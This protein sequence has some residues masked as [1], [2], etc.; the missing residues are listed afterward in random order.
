MNETQEIPSAV[1]S[2]KVFVSAAINNPD[3]LAEFP[4]VGEPHFH[5]PSQRIVFQTLQTFSALGKPF[6]LRLIIQHLIDTGRL[7]MAG[8]PSEVYGLMTYEVYSHNVGFH[9]EILQ[10][11]LARRMALKAANDII[12]AVYQQDDPQ[13]LLDATSAPITAIHDTLLSIKPSETMRNVVDGIF[14]DLE[15]KLNGTKT[16]MGIPT[17]IPIIDRKF[18]GLHRG[19]STIISGYPSGGK[20][21]LAGQLCAAAFLK[22]HRTLFVSLEMSKS[23][24]TQRI[25][26]YVA[27]IK[28]MAI[29]D[30]LQY[31]LD[32]S[33]GDRKILSKNELL[34]LQNA[35]KTILKSPFD[36]EYLNAAS[37]QTIAAVIRKHHR[38]SPLS[39]VAVDYAQ[40]IRAS[41]ETKSQNREQ[42]LSHSSKVLADLARELNF[43]LLLLS[44]LNKTGEAKHAEALNEDCD[45]HWQIMQDKESKEHKGIAVPKD[46]HNGQ[47]GLL[48]PVTLNE[49]MVRFE[50][51]TTKHP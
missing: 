37:E 38:K 28:G 49:K 16:P 3:V 43:S 11:R 24:I 35:S 7:E 17:D 18:K 34:T 5:F 1:M 9:A 6:D 39:V 2:E 19:R 12:G 8:G 44:Q 25:L 45:V 30:P 29:T 40:R 20:S 36:I 13:E 42:Q 27:R 51:K 23:E 46:R 48:M 50:E 21:V 10:D 32:E 22:D 4:H 41:S 14:S 26:A 15:A 31:A 33:N 47:C